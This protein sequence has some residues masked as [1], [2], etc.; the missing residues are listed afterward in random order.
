[1]SALKFKGLTNLKP[2]ILNILLKVY[3]VVS[4]PELRATLRLQSISYLRTLTWN[5]SVSAISGGSGGRIPHTT[6]FLQ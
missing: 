2:Y 6:I 4:S 5:L 3:G 1:M